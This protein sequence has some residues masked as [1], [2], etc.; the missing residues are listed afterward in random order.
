M[1]EQ[2]EGRQKQLEANHYQTKE[3]LLK[4][5]TVLTEQQK[6]IPSELQHISQLQKAIADA[7]LHKQTLFTQ[8]ER[9]QKH[10][11][12]VEKYVATTEEVV[13]QTTQQITDLEAKLVRAKDEF[14]QSLVDAGFENYKHFESSIRNDFQVNHLQNQYMEFSKALHTITTQ[15]QQ[16][17]EELE[18]KEKVDLTLIEE[19]LNA[20]K[21]E[22]ENALHILNR[23]VQYEGHAIDFSEK[24]DHVADKIYQ[25]EEIS[26]Q[27]IDLHNL[28]RGQNSKKISLNAM[29]KWGI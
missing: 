21:L 10:L 19:A 5:S 6:E 9:V 7:Q 24:L 25:L 3:Q 26:S 13:K 29:Y 20:L 23:S 28:L 17:S 27:I 16:D 18:G 15:V 14:K 8:W 4:E 2:L 12:E 1:V 22:Y 11:H